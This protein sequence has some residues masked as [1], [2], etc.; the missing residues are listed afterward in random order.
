MWRCV[1]GERE[2]WLGHVCVE[3]FLQGATVLQ[4]GKRNK[5][6]QAKNEREEGI[7]LYGAAK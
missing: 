1:G 6:L 3:M 4:E 2:Q 7:F 5:V